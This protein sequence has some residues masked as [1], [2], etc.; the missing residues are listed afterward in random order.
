MGGVD[1]QNA[2]DFLNAR[3]KSKRKGDDE[4]QNGSNYLI[5]LNF[6]SFALCC[7]LAREPHFHRRKPGN[8]KGP[9]IQR[10][11]RGVFGVFKSGFVAR[12]W[13]T[14]G[15]LMARSNSRR[16]SEERV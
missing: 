13:P 15:D 3:K 5:V 1:Y 6:L 16:I 10:G 12:T 14:L 2:P 4:E 7:V 8:G 11:Y 9:Q